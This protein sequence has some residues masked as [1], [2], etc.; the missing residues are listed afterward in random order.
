[1]S[2]QDYNVL[3]IHN[4]EPGWEKEWGRIV[5]VLYGLSSSFEQ[6]DEVNDDDNDVMQSTE[7]TIIRKTLEIADEFP[8]EDN[9]NFDDCCNPEISSV[10]D[11]SNDDSGPRYRKEQYK[12]SPLYRACKK[13]ISRP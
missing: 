2:K 5:E 1:M 11:F 4:H 6:E 10:E 9:H 13:V 8:D 3:M 12:N 7:N